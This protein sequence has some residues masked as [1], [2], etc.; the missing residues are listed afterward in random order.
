M[1]PEEIRIFVYGTLKPGHKNYR[2]YCLGK[3]VEEIKAI[4]FGQLFALSAG[5]PA[6]TLGDRQIQGFLLTFENPT[7]LEHL[8]RLE[9]FDPK[10]PSLQNEYQRQEIEIYNPIGQPLG[11]AWVY[12][13]TPKQVS[14]KGGLPLPSGS[15]DEKF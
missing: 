15:W 4:A 7:I 10:R 8:D 1:P 2:R 5:Y 12:L 14:Q 11:S 3:V 13:M 9:G 6:M